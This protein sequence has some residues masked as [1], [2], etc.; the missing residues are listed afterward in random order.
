MM[1]DMKFLM[2]MIVAMA[3]CGGGSSKPAT[4]DTAGKRKVA[5]VEKGEKGSQDEAGD[6]VKPKAGK[7]PKGAAKEG[8][9]GRGKSRTCLDQSKL[10]DGSAASFAG[11]VEKA[12][13]RI[14]QVAKGEDDKDVR[15]CIGL[16]PM[17][18]RASKV[19]NKALAPAGELPQ[20]AL[21]TEGEKPEACSSEGK[22]RALGRKATKAV[23]AALAKEGSVVVTTDASL[24]AVSGERREVW[25]VAKD[26]MVK[27][28]APRAVTKKYVKQPAFRAV[29][30]QLHVQ[31]GPCAEPCSVA[32][33][34]DAKGKVLSN[35]L[36]TEDVPHF[37]DDQRWTL[38]ADKLYVFDLGSGKRLHAIDLFPEGPKYTVDGTTYQFSGDGI[39]S[40]P[41]IPLGDGRVAILFH[42][43]PVVAIAN[44]DEGKLEALYRFPVCDDADARKDAEELA[45]E[46]A[47]DEKK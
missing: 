14:C 36:E 4:N 39:R 17:T 40:S 22:C 15:A 37:L 45:A 43:E 42:D 41:S 11:A 26:K 5:K 2:A 16:D 3:A 28:K 27:L 23:K 18:G 12:G 34:F 29:G 19:S 13:L 46:P 32:R 6:G 35:D 25:N 47:S 10:P 9:W 7:R 8:S 24:V 20:G 33:V 1:S 38:L 30:A 31:W 44:V 21:K